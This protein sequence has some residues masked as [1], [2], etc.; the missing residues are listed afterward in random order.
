MKDL[1][2]ILEGNA[3]SRMRELPAESVHLIITSPPYWGLR[4]YKIPGS[5]W[6]GDENCQHIWGEVQRTAWANKL[7]GPN[8]QGLHGGNRCLTTKKHGQWCHLCNAWFGVFGLEPSPDLYVQNA[9]AIFREARRILR[10]D[11]TMWV[12]LGDSFSPTGGDRRTHGNG[13]NSIVGPT[14]DASMP[15]DG[16]IEQARH[17]K[18]AGLKAGDLVGIPW[19]V[20]F[21]L[22]ADGWYLRRDNIWAKPN[23]MPE[24]VIGWRWEKCRIK[25]K[26]GQT[27]DIHPS[28]LGGS[29]KSRT[30]NGERAFEHQAEYVDC[31]GCNKCTANAGLVLRRGNWR[32]TTSHEY[33]FQ[34]SK[35]SSYFCD[36]EAAREKATGNAHHRGAGVNPKSIG[37]NSRFK[38]SRSLEAEGKPSDIRHK[39]NRS[40][41]AAVRGLVANRN[42]RSVWN[43]P[44]RPYRGA[45]FATFP[46]DLIRPIVR[47]ASPAF[48]CAQCGSPFA[49][50]IERGKP[51]AAQ[52]RACGGD[53]NGKYN[54][55]ATKEFEFHGAQNASSVKARILAGMVE[56]TVVGYRASCDCGGGDGVK[57]IVLDMFAGSG[58]VGQVAIEEG[59][60]A[61]LIEIS[62]AYVP[63]IRKRCEVMAPLG[64]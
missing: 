42:M 32:C 22:Q 31:P 7:K 58:T 63:L 48:C 26:V 13:F 37:K 5:V 52:Q 47:A 62:A 41:S 4:D 23:P 8:A 10:R 59:R 54:G 60:S 20:A 57:A 44:T 49:P 33:V 55:Q 3:I 51:L 29:D 64:L 36:G 45:H 39:R 25:T 11:G 50:V 27:K 1:L 17:L 16:R 14:A 34:F 43:I 38:K 15:R 53:A 56:K 28:R 9:V 61:I 35:S 2:T 46:A 6:G 40:F 18:E 12:N 19:R 21:A 24:S 30:H